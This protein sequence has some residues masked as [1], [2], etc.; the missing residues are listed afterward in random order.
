MVTKY[1]KGRHSLFLYNSEIFYAFT[2]DILRSPQY[3]FDYN[4]HFQTIDRAYNSGTAANVGKLSTVLFDKSKLPVGST[5]NLVATIKNTSGSTQNV[6]RIIYFYGNRWDGDA[7]F[8]GAQLRLPKAENG[9]FTDVAGEKTDGQELSVTYKKDTGNTA[10]KYS[11]VENTPEEV[12]GFDFSG[13][14]AGGESATYTIPMTIDHYTMPYNT[15]VQK[16]VPGFDRT[17]DVPE[18]ALDG[19]NMNLLRT[20]SNAMGQVTDYLYDPN[21]P[22]D[23]TQTPLFFSGLAKQSVPS[24]RTNDIGANGTIAN[25][26]VVADSQGNYKFDPTDVG[27]PESQASNI[28]INNINT[29]N[30]GFTLDPTK[31]LGSIGTTIYPLGD[32][33]GMPAPGMNGIAQY[34]LILHEKSGDDSIADSLVTLN[35]LPNNAPKIIANNATV[36]TSDTISGATFGVNPTDAVMHILDKNNTIVPLPASK[37]LPEGTYSVLFTMQGAVSKRVTLTVTSKTNPTPSNNG[38]NSSNNSNNNGGNS[39][40]NAW[41]PSTPSNPNGTGLPNYAAVK[42]SAVFANKRIYMY[43]HADFKKSERIATYPKSKRVNNA[44]FV[45]L[46]YA[47]SANGALRYKVRDVNHHSKTDGKIGYITANPKYVVNVYY[48]TMP[49]NGKITVINKK[50][51]HAYKHANL[52]GRVK[53]F[54]KGTHITVKSFVKHNLT[55]RYKLSNGTYITANKK[56]VIQGTY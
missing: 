8:I 55:T 19:S 22:T 20:F 42:G 24:Y 37:T 52:T 34:K 47:R 12:I 43:R 15:Q 21:H 10:V 36:A 53:T 35:V 4:I 16:T 11:Y 33:N 3:G 5:V 54:K 51:I 30:G 13:P 6:H 31:P 38:G 45:V 26:N 14:L 39:G 7:Q 27:I 25:L 44:M 40:N 41:N 46:D 17:S 49:K 32:S 50:G 28:V 48:K 18:A 1:H 56:L 2:Q 9:T 23:Y 29:T